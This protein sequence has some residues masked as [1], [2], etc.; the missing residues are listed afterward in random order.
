VHGPI[1]RAG[2]NLIEHDMTW[3]TADSGL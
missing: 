1:T 3:T 2:S